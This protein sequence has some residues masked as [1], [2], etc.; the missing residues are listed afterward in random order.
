[1]EAFFFFLIW[2]WG[3]FIWTSI[4]T[5]IGIGLSEIIRDQT[6]EPCTQR[7]EKCVNFIH[8]HSIP[9]SLLF[10]GILSLSLLDSINWALEKI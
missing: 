3:F 5:S 9:F 4:V 1:M 6:K 8:R 7:F 10:I 2:A